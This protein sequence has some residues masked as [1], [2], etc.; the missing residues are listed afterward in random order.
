MTPWAGPIIELEPH[1]FTCK[2]KS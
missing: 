2:K 1:A